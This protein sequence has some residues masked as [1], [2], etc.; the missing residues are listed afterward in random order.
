ME[1][2][3]IIKIGGNVIDN[4][5]SLNEF[6][7][8]FATIKGKKIL[9]HGGGKIADQ[10]LNKLYIP[11][12]MHEGKRITDESTMQIVTMVYAGLINKKI[13]ATLQKLNCNAIGL[14]GADGNSI[15]AEKRTG[16]EIDYGLVGDI[17]K[18]NTPFLINLLD[19]NC[20][21]VF[22]AITHN[23]QGN[24]LNSNADG[25]AS[26][27][28]MALSE[29]YDVQLTYCF[30]KQGVL[31]DPDNN[32]SVIANISKEEYE[33]KKANKQIHSGMIPKLDHAFKAK[34]QGV[35]I[36]KIG[37]SEK[38]QELINQN[39]TNGTCITI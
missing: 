18:V 25:I 10:L 26:H 27:L 31:S 29:Q 32:N 4:E 9:V 19:Q 34:Q 15:L 39:K 6:L 35:A 8:S 20:I 30:E 11:V 24:L 3:H 17:K 23:Q 21:P 2:L 36:V 28:S 22:S 13:A 33:N 38:V 7:H 16:T 14:C 37:S 5:E 1:K 12:Q